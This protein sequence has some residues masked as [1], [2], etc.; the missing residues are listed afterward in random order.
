MLGAGVCW[1]HGRLLARTCEATSSQRLA[2]QA[3]KLESYGAGYINLA[4]SQGHLLPSEVAERIRSVRKALKIPIGFHP[5]NN[6]G[7]ANGNILAAIDEGTTYIDGSLK[8]FGGGAGNAQTESAVAMLKRAG[9]DVNANLFWIMDA[10]SVFQSKAVGREER[11]SVAVSPAAKICAV[12]TASRLPPKTSTDDQP[13][14]RVAPSARL[15]PA[16]ALLDLLL[17]LVELP[18]LTVYVPAL[19]DLD[20][21]SSTANMSSD[22]S[23]RQRRSLTKRRHTLRTAGPLSRRKSTIVLKAGA[24]R[25]V[26]RIISTLRW[27]CRS[28]R[29]GGYAVGIPRRHF[30]GV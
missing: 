11:E 29:A 2:E 20:L 21:L 15:H 10:A 19:T 28:G 25:R 12:T 18:C 23:F 30:V 27:H 4:E 17:T 8:G 1:P 16:S 6:L 26:S 14:V 22:S 24:R 3:S 13:T 5:H 9:H 7:L